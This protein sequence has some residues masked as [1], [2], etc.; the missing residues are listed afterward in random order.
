MYSR[1]RHMPRYTQGNVD[2]MR[3]WIKGCISGH[4]RCRE[5]QQRSIHGSQRPTRILEVFS[6]HVQLRCD[7]PAEDIYT[8]M[9]LSHMWGNN[10]E[11]QLRLVEERL[12]EFKKGIPLEKLPTIYTKAID[13][14]LSL[15][16]RY[17]WI[18]SLCIIQDSPLD[19]QCEANKMA[20]V[21]GNALCNIAFLSPPGIRTW[22]VPDDLRARVPCVIRQPLSKIC[23]LYVHRRKYGVSQGTHCNQSGWPLFSRAWAFQEHLLCP[24]TILCGGRNLEWE[25]S[26]L[27]CDEWLC[28]YEDI[29]SGLTKSSFF[30]RFLETNIDAPSMTAPEMLSFVTTWE[31]LVKE[32]RLRA[33]TKPEDRIIAFTGIARA[34][35]N[36]RQLTYLAGIWAECLSFGLLWSVPTRSTSVHPSASANSLTLVEPVLQTVPTWS[37]FSVP[38]FHR[39]CMEFPFTE[40]ANL[41]QKNRLFRILDVYW[42]SLCSFK[43]PGQPLN[44]L[45]SHSFYDFA[46]MQIT[47]AM[48]TLTTELRLGDHDVIESNV[49]DQVLDNVEWSRFRCYL[50]T[51]VCDAEFPLKVLLGLLGE[52]HENKL[53]P[54]RY[55]AGLAL[56]PGPEKSTWKRVG[57]WTMDF[58]LKEGWVP[59]KK[60]C[61]RR[62]APLFRR[63]D[64]VK[65]EDITLV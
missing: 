33:L 26:S 6:N 40:H 24:R 49:M 22:E 23:G 29:M 20:S 59:L 11:A 19:W 42:A 2:L 27:R 45:P 46:G 1:M 13:I 17:I 30:S 8:Y 21:Y 10:P 60:R 32:Y 43:W 52:I 55:C 39:H 4:D 65:T 12:D 56:A 41:T 35:H 50:D 37:W 34:I 14:T 7:L 5:F 38:I 31:S 53:R 57:M 63:L 51:V 9:T 54:V 15:G 44:H 18:D 61:P 3:F 25:C 64:G 36:I 28:S 58:G 47:V 62:L 48:Q 16:V